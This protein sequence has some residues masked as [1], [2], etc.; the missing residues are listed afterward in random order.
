MVVEN[1]ALA[2]SDFFYQSS[3]VWPFTERFRF[4]HQSFSDNLWSTKHNNRSMT[5]A[6]A[7]YISKTT[8]KEKMKYIYR[9]FKQNVHAI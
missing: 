6:Q 5:E 9:I 7:K 2:S 3:P 8:P 4:L 1:D